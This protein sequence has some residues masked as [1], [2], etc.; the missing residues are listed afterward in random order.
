LL[1]P[2]TPEEGRPYPY[3]PEVRAQRRGPML[4]MAAEVGLPVVDRDWISNSRKALEASEFAREQGLFDAFHRAVFHAYFAEGSDIGKLDELQAIADAVG[5]D[6]AALADAL[7]EGRYSQRVEDD[8]SLAWR[9]GFSGVPAFILGNRAI[10]GA[11]PYSVFEEVM[12]L[13]GREKRSTVA[14]SDSGEP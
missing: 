6:G 13:L 5:L 7:E 3:P 12:E 10:V 14:A 9:I 11:Q 8:V 1:D 4:A 2:T